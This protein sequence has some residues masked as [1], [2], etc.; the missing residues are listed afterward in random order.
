MSRQ[1]I[2]HATPDVSVGDLYVHDIDGWVRPRIG[3]ERSYWWDVAHRN[4]SIIFPLASI[5]INA[6]WLL[7]GVGANRFKE[8]SM[9]EEIDLL[10]YAITPHRLQQDTLHGVTQY[11]VEERKGTYPRYIDAAVGFAIQE[12]LRM[13]RGECTQAWDSNVSFDRPGG[14]KNGSLRMRMA[15][16]PPSNAELV[17]DALHKKLRRGSTA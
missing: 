12:Y 6:H 11:I 7:W 17:I 15:Y 4:R 14:I 1:T 8:R 9:A 5:A 10:P 3:A 13:V 16:I 2:I